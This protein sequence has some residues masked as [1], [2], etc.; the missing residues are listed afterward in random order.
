MGKIALSKNGKNKGK[1]FALV[2]DEDF[3]YL[4]QFNWCFDGQYAQRRV[5]S[6]TIRMHT[7]LLRTPNGMEVDHINENKL[8]NR[9]GNLRIC[10]RSENTVNQKARGISKYR[11]VSYKKDSHKWIA[12]IKKNY[13]AYRI[14]SFNTEIEAAQA[15]DEK[16]KE[17]HGTFVQ[18][19]FNHV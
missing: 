17:L 14:G 13:K 8:D 5:D 16:A 1:F 18:L 6:K 19:N 3:E 2:D 4:N 9:R 11:G 10:N 15:Y 12:Q 7:F